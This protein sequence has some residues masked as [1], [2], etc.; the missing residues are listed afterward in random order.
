MRSGKTPGLF[1]AATKSARPSGCS[2]TKR[3]PSGGSYR[4]VAAPLLHPPLPDHRRGGVGL[5]VVDPRPGLPAPRADPA[6]CRRHA[7][8]AEQ[9]AV[10]GERVVAAHIA[11]GLDAVEEGRGVHAGDSDSCRNRRQSAAAIPNKT[12]TVRPALLWRFEPHPSLPPP[13]IYGQVRGQCR[14]GAGT[15]GEPAWGGN[16]TVPTTVSAHG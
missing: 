15:H 9:V 10:D 16:A 4:A 6:P 1:V 11:G 7:P 12:A 13:A 5:V 14:S 3:S 2:S 8:H